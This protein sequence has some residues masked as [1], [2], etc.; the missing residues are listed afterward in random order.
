MATGAFYRVKNGEEGAGTI[1]WQEKPNTR[2]IPISEAQWAAYSNN[3]N[4]FVDY[5]AAEIDAL[6]V[7]WGQNNSPTV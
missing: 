6:I 1:Y 5:S 4:K 3:G 2:L 7:E